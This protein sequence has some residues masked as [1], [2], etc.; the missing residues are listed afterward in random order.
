MRLLLRPRSSLRR[1]NHF[2]FI[3]LENGRSNPAVFLCRIAGISDARQG[4]KTEVLYENSA[5]DENAALR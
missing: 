1:T 5:R 3:T 4:P 2:S